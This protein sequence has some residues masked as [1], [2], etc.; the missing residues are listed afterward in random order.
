LGYGRRSNRF[1]AR[2]ECQGWYGMGLRQPSIQ[3]IESDQE[4]Q[5]WYEYTG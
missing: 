5:Q 3:T 1:I 4:Y 2:Q